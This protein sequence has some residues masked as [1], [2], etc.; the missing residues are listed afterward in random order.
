MEILSESRI[1]YPR[2]QVYRAYRD[3]LP[4]IAALIPDVRAVKVYARE[5]TPTGVKLHNEWQSDREIP[6]M[7]SKLIRPDQLAWD[8][9]AEWNDAGSY[10][11][12]II[13][14]RAF[15]EAVRCS[16]RNHI[17]ADGDHATV[18]R[19]TG[20]LTID[21]REVPGVP[22]FLASRLAPQVEKFIVSLITPNLE[23]VNACI[24]RFLDGETT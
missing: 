1:A 9:Y 17:L 2:E 18:V 13:R 19:L 5:E 23:Q 22:G 14:P 11:D 10:V 3:R 7:V 8:D 4:E 21:I 6:A 12:W 20:D 16:G 24:E 15:R